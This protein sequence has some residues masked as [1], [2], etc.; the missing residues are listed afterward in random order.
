MRPVVMP[1]SLIHISVYSCFQL[2]YLLY[3]IP[4]LCHIRVFMY[5]HLHLT[6]EAQ[7]FKCLQK[8]VTAG[9][10]K[11]VRAIGTELVSWSWTTS[12]SRDSRG[13]PSTFSG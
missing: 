5:H 3:V 1:F 6:L 2:L 10:G 11:V 9:R 8:G 12:T 7:G 4:R 13:H